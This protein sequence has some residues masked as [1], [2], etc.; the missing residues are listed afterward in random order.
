MARRQKKLNERFSKEYKRSKTDCINTIF[1]RLINRRHNGKDFTIHMITNWIYGR[2][3]NEVLDDVFE[4]LMLEVDPDGL[5][6]DKRKL[7]QVL[8]PA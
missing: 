1:S 6:D 4:N 2:N 5:A 7:N 8:E 3:E